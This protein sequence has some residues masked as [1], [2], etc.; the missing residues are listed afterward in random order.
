MV[1]KE[2]YCQYVERYANMVLRI[3]VNYCKNISDAEDMVQEVF[4]R[5]YEANKNFQD[6][7]YVKRWLIRVTINLCKNHLKSAW[8]QKIH[9]FDSTNIEDNLG[10]L[11]EFFEEDREKME[12][13]SAVKKLPEKYR[14]VVH[15]YYYEEY[16]IRIIAEILQK[17]ETTIQTR[18]TR[19]RSML[20]EQ[21]KGAWHDE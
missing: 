16:P 6:D 4:L 13:Y 10:N 21:L 15:L 20:K 14:S 2:E 3:S 8:H 18:L 11:T 5:L 7:E 12:L 17:K 19:A 1:S 9:F